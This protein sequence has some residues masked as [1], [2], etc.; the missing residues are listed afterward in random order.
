MV[1]ISDRVVSPLDNN[2]PPAAEENSASKQVPNIIL[3]F[4]TFHFMTSKMIQD[5]RNDHITRDI[6]HC[7]AMISSLSKVIGL[8]SRPKWSAIVM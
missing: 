7:G 4:S 8:Q 5:D 1:G 2:A 6:F 3:S